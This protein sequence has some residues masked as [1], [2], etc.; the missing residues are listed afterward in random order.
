MC[1]CPGQD[2]QM[3]QQLAGRLGAR[4]C[5][6]DVFKRYHYPVA[7]RYHTSQPPYLNDQQAFGLIYE[8]L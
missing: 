7:W 6:G 2:F 3:V 4:D 1:S 5:S 8:D